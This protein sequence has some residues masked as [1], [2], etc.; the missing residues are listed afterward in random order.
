[1]TV[2]IPCNLC[3]SSD[4]RLLFPNTLDGDAD[5]GSTDRYRCTSSG[6]GRHH[7]I[8]RCRRCGLVYACPREGDDAVERSYEAVVDELYL[9]ERRGRVLTF[10]RNFRPILKLMEG[11]SQPRLLDVGCYVGIFLEIAAGHGWE[12][13]G[14]EP[15]L[16]AAEEARRRGLQ[17]YT[18]TLRSVE[19]PTA[20]FDVVTLWDVIEHFTDPR[21]ELCRINRVLKPGGLVCI[22]T[23]DIGSLLPRILGP[24]WPWLMEMHLYYFS[25][26]TMT[27]MLSTTGFRV[28]RQFTQGRYVLLDYLFA[29]LSAASPTLSNTLRRAARRLGVGGLAIPVNLGDLFTTL[30]RKVEEVG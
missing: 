29:Q 7:A 6:Y 27:E 1:M 5:S 16:W 20:Y 13:C 12:V 22:H 15:S 24:N 17:V 30:A 25:R 28:I 9:E 11:T 26:R 21:E 3:G 2:S 10:E 23:I 18:G 4:A 14:V 8:V 19:L